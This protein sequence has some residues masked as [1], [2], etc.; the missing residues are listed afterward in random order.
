MPERIF[1]CIGYLKFVLIHLVIVLLILQ[2][3]VLDYFFVT[4][5]LVFNVD[6]FLHYTLWIHNSQSYNHKTKK[7][8]N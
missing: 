3:T 2:T 4:F 7:I 1:I 8:F 5:S 6:F